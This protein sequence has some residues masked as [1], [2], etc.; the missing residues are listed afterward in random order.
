[1]KRLLLIFAVLIAFAANAQDKYI[2][3]FL[4]KRTDLPALP[5]EESDK[6]MEGHMANINKMAKEGKLVAAGPFGRWRRT[7]HFQ[8]IVDQRSYGVD[9]S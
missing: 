1:M 9:E 7:L 8:I 5:K 3:V 2:F 6:L 4:N